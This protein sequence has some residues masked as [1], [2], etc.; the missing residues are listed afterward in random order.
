MGSFLTLQL[1]FWI[2]MTICNLIYFYTMNALIQ[3][4]TWI[5]TDATHYMYN[6]IKMQLIQLMQLNC[7]FTRTNFTWL[8]FNYYAI[9]VA[10]SCRC[11]ISCIHDCELYSFL[12]QLFYKC[13]C[14]SNILQLEQLHCH[15]MIIKPYS[16]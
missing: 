6:W 1:G 3:V 7:N 9:I 16:L 4:C 8:V 2:A 11:C 15:L 12:L 5:V 10:T 14:S 13:R